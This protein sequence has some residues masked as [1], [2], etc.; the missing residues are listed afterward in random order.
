MKIYFNAN[1]ERFTKFLNHENLKLYGIYEYF[2]TRV[3][4]QLSSFITHPSAVLLDKC[5]VKQHVNQLEDCFVELTE[6][7]YEILVEKGID[8][9]RLHARLVSLDVF[10]RHEHQEFVDKHLMNIDQNMTFN[11]LWARLGSYW[12]FLNFDLLEHI[13]NKFGSEDLKQKMKSYKHDLQ[14]FR[15]STRLCDFI[16]CWPVRG[17]TPPET[18]LRRFVVKVGHH[19]DSCTLEDLETL[20]GV[21]TRKLFLPGFALQLEEIMKGSI[22]ITWLI[23]VPFVKTLMEAIET[24]GSEFFL[25]QKIET[26]T[27]DGQVWYP[28]PTRKPV[29]YHKEQ[30]QKLSVHPK[31]IQS[32]HSSKHQGMLYSSETAPVVDSAEHRAFQKHLAVLSDGISDPGWLAIQLYSRDMISRDMIR[33]AQLETIPAPTRTRKLLSAV[34]NQILTSPEPKF[35][36]LLDILHSEPSL[37]HIARKLEEAY[38][39]SKLEFSVSLLVCYK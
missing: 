14:S 13:I 21:I 8:V 17:Q 10:R 38:S 34:E 12:D 15:R 3:T 4:L 23:P 20:K 37:E 30:P 24:T 9:H 26:I 5:S 7:T 32:K 27:I 11:N 33:E 1:L 29:D 16:D 25:E 6:C 19:W 35:R 28:S 39:Y 36:D 18:E 2:R 31:R 22:T